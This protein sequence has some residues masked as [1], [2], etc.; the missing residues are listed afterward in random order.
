M[1]KY[2][3]YEKEGLVVSEWQESDTGPA[4]RIYQLTKPGE[5][6]LADWANMIR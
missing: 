5:S 6:V 4:K 1:N 3:D 2:T